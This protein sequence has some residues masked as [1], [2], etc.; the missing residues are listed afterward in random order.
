MIELFIILAC[1]AAAYL[2]LIFPRMTGTPDR[3]PFERDFAH[4][5]LWNEAEGI[6]ENSLP[7]FERAAQQDFA[8]EL[9][10]QLSKDGEVVVFHDETLSRMCGVEGKVCEKTLAELKALRLGGTAEAIPTFSEVLA[11]VNGRVPLLVE[12]KGESSD[13]SLCYKVAPILDAYTG[14]YCVES[15][16]PVLLRFYK[17][18]RPEVLRGQLVTDLIAAKKPGKKVLNW[19]LSHMWLNFLSRPDFVAC[20]RSYTRGV[21]HTI[22]RMLRRPFYLWT[23]QKEDQLRYFH[24]RGDKCIFDHFIPKQ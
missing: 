7:A 16:N 3:K 23:I 9:D 5:G 18:R 20:D 11:A 2:F 17:A 14:A 4:R 1:L 15:F 6:P 24:K 12:L 22:L 19:A 8:I 10:V 21:S 13:D